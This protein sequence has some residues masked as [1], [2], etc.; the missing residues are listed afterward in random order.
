M[1]WCRKE[2]KWPWQ[3]RRELCQP[4]LMP[5]DLCAAVAPFALATKW[6]FR[7]AMETP[8]D[9]QEREPAEQ[10][11]AS[12]DYGKVYWRERGFHFPFVL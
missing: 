2:D 7:V 11:M 1:D 9:L 4:G 5:G 6:V 3:E 10:I 8:L 12:T